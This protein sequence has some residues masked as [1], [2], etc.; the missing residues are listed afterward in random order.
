[1]G[2]CAARMLVVVGGDVELFAWD[3]ALGGRWGRGEKLVIL[4][5]VC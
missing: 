3:D 5:G 4:D 2:R 1:M